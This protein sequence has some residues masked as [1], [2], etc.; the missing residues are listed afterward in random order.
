MAR[1]QKEGLDYF[2]HDTDAV[3]DEKIE[4]LRALYGNDGYAFFFILLER[5]YRSPNAELDVSDAETLQILARKVS[6]TEEKFQEML[7]TAIKRGCFN[8]EAFEKRGVLTSNGIRKRASVVIEKRE[9][10][11]VRYQK[12]KLDSIPYPISDAETIPETPQ[13]KVKYSKVNNICIL[14]EWIDK[15]T[16][17]AFLEMRRKKRAVPTE[18]AKELLIKELDKLRGEGHNPNEVL[19][20]SIMRNYTGVFPLKGGESGAHRQS[21][22]QLP[23][24]YRGPEEIFGD[25]NG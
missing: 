11:R 1:P 23:K 15:D 20:Q 8:K 14:P 4:A 17:E 25:R 2:S 3:N 6:V 5:I 18:R 24:T 12:A 13:S 10:M 7:K 16:W 22:R 9:V 19:N 21:S